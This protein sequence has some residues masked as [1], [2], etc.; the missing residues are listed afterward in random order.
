MVLVGALAGSVGAV[1]VVLI[2]G[3][4]VA[5]FLVVDVVTGKARGGRYCVDMAL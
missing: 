2:V 5:R 4:G 3:V 1:V